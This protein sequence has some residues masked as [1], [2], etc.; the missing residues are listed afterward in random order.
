MW[1]RERWSIILLGAVIILLPIAAMLQYRW[2]G[3]VADAERE[4]MRAVLRAAVSQ[5]SETVDREITRA[6]SLFQHHGAGDLERIS[7]DYARR[8]DEWRT[9]AAD[10]QIVRDLYVLVTGEQSSSQLM[11]W[12]KEAR[13]FSPA[14][15]PDELAV[16]RD[17]RE[18]ES[19]YLREDVPALVIPA[20]GETGI[21]CTVVVLD[22]EHI[23]E[24]FIPA[25]AAR[26]FGSGANDGME[27]DV[28][29]ISRRDPAHVIWASR[30]DSPPGGAS[31]DA[32]HPLFD[33]RLQALPLEARVADG[34]PRPHERSATVLRVFRRHTAGAD[35]PR[36]S[37]R[38]QLQVRHRAGSLEV[39]IASARQR[40]L[41]I[42]FGVLLLLGISVGFIVVS[43]RRAMRLADDQ[44]R[45]VAGVTHELRTPLAVICSAGENLADGVV[46]QPAQTREYGAL[47]RDEG[48]RLSRMVEQVL[49]Y[50]GARYGRS[51]YNLEP[52]DIRE[53]IGAAIRDCHPA[54]VQGSFE[55]EQQV[56]DDLPLVNADRAALQRAIQNLLENAIKYDRGHRSIKIS[57]RKH[58][59][60]DGGEEVRV[61]VEDAGSG[62]AAADLPH[63]F[64]P[65]YRGAEV[66]AAQVKGSGLGLSLVQHIVAAHGG[67][68]SVD[69]T[70]GKGSAFT[71]HLPI[72]QR[73]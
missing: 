55:L 29:V 30:H 10:P 66:V 38:W 11:R 12:D 59:A 28:A 50:A 39:A 1:K 68:V 57:A 45:F 51:A 63:I 5:F 67:R 23:R 19:E 65:F 20:E 7:Q 18:I 4:R 71:I 43:S 47:V 58:A 56:D 60:A 35:E 72:S 33:V 16:L 64:D 52:A 27:Y 48:R 73:A 31:A 41:V 22:R 54:L 37:G 46:N 32:V 69:T 9:S 62:I 15:W 40:N 44:L 53:I 21:T 17:E 24:V 14:D 34:A 2:L 6:Y 26:Y 49:E 36:E 25:L 3:R 61:T 8:F 42:S 70:V 13:G